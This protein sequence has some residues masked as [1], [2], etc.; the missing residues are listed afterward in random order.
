[1]SY[2]TFEKDVVDMSRERDEKVKIIKLKKLIDFITTKCKFSFLKTKPNFY[3]QICVAIY[4]NQK[5]IFDNKKESVWSKT[6]VEFEPRYLFDS[7]DFDPHLERIRLESF[8][9]IFK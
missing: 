7:I 5:D 2:E 4:E 9:I 8:N 3:M 1:M 6:N